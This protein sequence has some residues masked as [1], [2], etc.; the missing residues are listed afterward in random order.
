MQKEKFHIVLGA[1]GN[2]GKLVINKLQKMNIPVKGISRSGQGPK[3]VEII[4]ADALRYEELARALKGGLVIYHCLGLPYPQWYEKHPIIMQN[5]IEAASSNGVETKIIFADN[6]YAYGKE[7]AL[8]GKL[9]ETTPENAKDRKG[10]LRKE[11][12]EMLIRAHHEGKIRTAIARASDFYGPN[13][14]NSLLEEFLIPFILKGKKAKFFADLDRKHS[15]V[16]L[17]DFVNALITL[18]LNDEAFGKVWVVPHHE[19]MSIKDFVNKFYTNNGS[20]N[21]NMVET[22]SQIILKLA[23]LFSPVIK[24]YRESNYQMHIDWVVDDSKFRKTFDFGTTPI[25]KAISETLEWYKNH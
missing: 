23:G 24:E 22:R 19:E 15:W 11:L 7:G 16:Y 2:S 18:A 12:G 10:I 13:A 20:K 1:N 9:S 14:S 6:L 5:L 3:S 8:L 4:K 25:D 17:P 21:G